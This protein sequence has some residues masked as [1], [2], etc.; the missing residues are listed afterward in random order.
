M[1]RLVLGVPVLVVLVG[2]GQSQG[3]IYSLI[4]LG[5][6]PGSAT[7][8]YAYAINN[9]GQVV[10]WGS[11]DGPA[12]HAFL[13]DP[14]AGMQ[15][16]GGTVA[17]DINDSGQV[18]GT[19]D[20]GGTHA[21]LWDPVIGMQDIAGG[22]AHGINNGGQVVGESNSHAFLWDQI[23][24]TQDLG[25]LSGRITSIAY[26]INEA[27]QVV[28]WSGGNSPDRAILW[29]PVEG[30]QNLGTLWAPVYGDGQSFAYGI[31]NDGQ[32]VG[33][34]QWGGGPSNCTAFLWDS[35]EGMRQIDG[36]LAYDINE[37]GQ[38]VGVY[39]TGQ[40]THR[41]MGPYGPLNDQLD[42]SGA[43]WILEY[44]YDINDTGQIV[45][46]GWGPD[47]YHGYLLTVIPE[48]STF[49]IWP[50]LGALALTIGWCRRRRGA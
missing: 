12:R 1:R 28:G 49:I 4:D 18:V 38:V 26:D 33:Q 35:V 22:I 10:G 14:V 2:V 34:V 48:P 30:I 39:I 9:A 45:G 3:A 7:T 21:V 23:G 37:G 31:N 40:G 20:V 46:S 36:S 5:E 15:D 44:A 42:A 13:W 29:D 27:G 17:H 43:G 32:V 16:L 41:A 8:N 47:G 19:S 24:G 11:V 6:L 25:V 50:L